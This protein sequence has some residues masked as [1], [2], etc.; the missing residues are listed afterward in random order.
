LG[1]VLVLI[2]VLSLPGDAG[3]REWGLWLALA[4]TIGILAGAC[5]SLREEGWPSRGEEVKTMPAPQP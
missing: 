5:V 3:G 1:L 2:R 4:S